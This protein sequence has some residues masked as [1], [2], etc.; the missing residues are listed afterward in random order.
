MKR[1][2]GSLDHFVI[3]TMIQIDTEILLRRRPTSS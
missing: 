2:L 1:F 3:K